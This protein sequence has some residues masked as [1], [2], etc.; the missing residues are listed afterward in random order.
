MT[1][2]PLVLVTGVTGYVGGRLTPRLLEAG[3][4]VRVLV[5]G[6]AQRLRNR[7]WRADVDV[8]VGDVLQPDD[9]AAA[10]Q[11]VDAAYYLIHSMGGHSEFRQRDIEAARNFGRAA[12][13]AGVQ[14]IVYLGGLGDP[15]SDLSEHLRS[16]QETGQALG[17]AGVPVTEFRAGMIVGSGSLSFEILRHLTE[18]VPIMLTPRW[19]RSRTQPIAIRDVLAYLIT[20]PDVAESAGQIVEIGGPDVLTY[21]DMI[22][23]YARIRGLRRTFISVP[24]LSPRLSS[25][26]VHWM[27]PI[28]ANIAR[29]L[30]DGLRNDTVLH[31][32]RAGTLFPEI[33][34]LRY[35]TAVQLALE[36]IE[37]GQIETLW[38]DALASSQGD[39]PPVYLAQEQG[40]L[41][42]RRQTVVDTSPTVV[43]RAFTGIGGRRG[44]PGYNWLWSIR[45]ILDRL[46]GGVGMRRGRRHPD[47]LREGEALDFWRVEKVEPNRRI[48][49]RAEMKL[50]GRGWL[51][52]ESLPTADGTQ[53]QLV[54]T[55]FFA[56]K[57]L[58]GLLYWYGIYPIHGLVFSRMI[59]QIAQRAEMLAAKSSGG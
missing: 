8:A 47:E 36:R 5:R 4:R 48:L 1:T 11:G 30:I 23:R 59:N 22:K 14:R 51:Q 17:E 37:Q 35:D 3:C 29:P 53:T 44:W 27:T 38:S 43:Y 15:T 20:A 31:H 21:L 42:E 2:Q 45:G 50:P 41:F 6:N 12:A 25:Y 39:L 19:T 40:M 49:L 24:V 13:D 46:I 7:P 57:G 16:R 9:L 55:A 33:D 56:P 52:F 18:R 28:P 26:W 58:F 32:D 10:M 54:Q 34:P